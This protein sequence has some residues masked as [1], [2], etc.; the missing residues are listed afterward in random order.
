MSSGALR[1]LFR[2]RDAWRCGAV[3]ADGRFLTRAVCGVSDSPLQDFTGG[4]WP[5]DDKRLPIP[6]HAAPIWCDRRRTG[7]VRGP[8]AKC[9]RRERGESHAPFETEFP[10]P[11][12]VVR[13]AL[14]PGRSGRSGVSGACSGPQGDPAPR[15]A[16]HRASRAAGLSG[17]PDLG[18]RRAGAGADDSGAPG[19]AG[20]APLRER[21]S[22]ALDRALARG[23]P[24]ERDGRCAGTHTAAGGARR[25]VSLRLRAARCRDLLVPLAS[26]GLRADGAGA[27]RC[28]RRR[29]A[30]SSRDRPRGA[31]SPR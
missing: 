19:R 18:V 13:T 14:R 3:R 24:R 26:S 11:R 10:A 2:G 31:P 8:G 9:E 23:S 1:T 29:G 30:R 17:N 22:P 21:T 5:G 6:R 15:Q 20:G 7:R 4:R 25:R 27:L 12:R 28:P 16:R